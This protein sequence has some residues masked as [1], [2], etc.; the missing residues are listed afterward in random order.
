MRTI[1]LTVEYDGSDFSGW[2]V[3]PRQRTIQ[4]EIEKALSHITQGPVRIIGSGRTDAGVH[5]LGQVASFQTES[6][7][8]LSAFDAGLNVLLPADVR[9]VRAE[10]VENSFHARRSAKRRVYRYCFAKEARVVGRQYAWYPRQVLSVDQLREASEPLLGEHDFT[11]FT[12]ADDE[13]ED[14]RSEILGIRWG[15]S[16]DEVRFDITATRFFHNMIRIILGTL[17]E[18]NRGKLSRDDFIRILN[19]GDRTKAG[20]T[21]PPQGLF[22][23]RVDY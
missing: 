5:A 18:V 4:G 2:Q 11:S 14:H 19:A 10:H 1:K 21:I 16:E 15:E 8:S 23:V 13:S 9:I 17:L 20:P 12:K 22:L 7:I 3:Q 6:T